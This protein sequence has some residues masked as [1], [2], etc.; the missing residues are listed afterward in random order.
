V[1]LL[2]YGPP[3]VAKQERCKQ[4]ANRAIHG[5]PISFGKWHQVLGGRGGPH[6]RLACNGSAKVTKNCQV[7]HR[8]GKIVSSEHHGEF[9]LRTTGECKLRV[10]V[11]I[12]GT[13]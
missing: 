5:N 12:G 7:N 1:N 3:A 6:G 8:A 13:K 11:R 2:T 4:S 9:G 10:S